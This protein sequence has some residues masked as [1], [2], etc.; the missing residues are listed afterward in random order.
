MPTSSPTARFISATFRSVWALELLLYLRTS[1]ETA[2]SRPE[3]VLQLRASDV[4]ISKSVDDLVAAGLIVELDDGMLRYSPVSP[5]LEKQVVE[6]E[7]LYRARPDAVRRM[8]I[9]S[10]AVGLTAFADAFKLK[11]DQGT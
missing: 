1:R 8:I 4:V 2:H 7:S 9:A 3:L 5:D 11:G 6:A 10:S